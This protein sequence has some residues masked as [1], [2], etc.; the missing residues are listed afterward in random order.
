MARLDLAGNLE[1]NGS[2]F[3]ATKSFEI[4]HPLKPGKKL[5]HSSLE[6]PEVG[7]YYRGIAKLE[8]GK[9]TVKLPDYFRALTR[10]EHRTLQLT[11]IGEIP[12]VLS[13]TGIRDGEFS[14][15]GTNP[16]GE[17]YWEV[18]AERADVEPLVV[19]K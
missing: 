2:L 19:E 10:P 3:A 9:A 14:V 7:V 8:K 18:K 11:A 15:Y 16:D 6:G 1:L 13:S 4:D 17:F 5:I 12:Y